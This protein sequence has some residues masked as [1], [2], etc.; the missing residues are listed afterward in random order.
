MIGLLQRKSNGNLKR[1]YQYFPKST[2]EHLAAYRV[3]PYFY[4][5]S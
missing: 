3:K 4:A 1:N 5:L 2:V